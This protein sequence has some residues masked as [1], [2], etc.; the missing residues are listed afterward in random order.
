M[1]IAAI[2]I[3]KE[4]TTESDTFD[5]HFFRFVCMC[6][7]LLCLFFLHSFVCF[8][9]LLFWNGAFVEIAFLTIRGYPYHAQE[10]ARIVKRIDDNRCQLIGWLNE[11]RNRKKNMADL[12]L[13]L[14]R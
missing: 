11:K 12:F 9:L 4:N 1:Y 5:M 10:N 7:H 14:F 3:R 6:A 8:A 2:G 13:F